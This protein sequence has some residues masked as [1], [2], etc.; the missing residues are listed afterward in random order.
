MY[1]S[2]LD[3]CDKFRPTS[4]GFTES[5]LLKKKKKRI[6]EELTI[7]S[8]LTL[9]SLSFQLV[10]THFYQASYCVQIHYSTRHLPEC[11]A[12]VVVYDAIPH[13]PLLSCPE[14][15]SRVIRSSAFTWLKSPECCRIK[16]YVLIPL[17]CHPSNC[18]PDTI[19]ATLLY[20]TVALWSF[21]SFSFP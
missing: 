13:N 5:D 16:C 18:N 12:A 8:V 17:P 10:E 19:S 7:T 15:G 20:F 9:V 21:S 14:P 1:S 6:F 4:S 11:I 3:R 2:H